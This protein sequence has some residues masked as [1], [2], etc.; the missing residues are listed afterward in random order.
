MGL[1]RI[2]SDMGLESFIE[3]I[4]RAAEVLESLSLFSVWWKQP[5]FGDTLQHSWNCFVPLAQQP[6]V[7]VNYEKLL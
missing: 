4:A 2:R 3:R 1:E 6:L 7:Y 5:F